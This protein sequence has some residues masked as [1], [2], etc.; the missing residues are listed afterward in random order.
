[1][2][3][4]DDRDV[5][6]IGNHLEGKNIALLITGGIAAYKSPS[7]IRHF[8]QYGANVKVYLSEEGKNFVTKDALSWATGQENYKEPVIERLSPNAEHLDHFDAYVIAPA[9]YNTIGKFAYGIADNAVTSVLASALGK[10]EDQEKYGKTNIIMMPTMHGSMQNSIYKENLEKLIQKGVRVVEP[11]YKWGKANLPD[12]H[13]IVV[14]TIRSISESYLKGKK[15]LITAGPTPASI[16]NVRAITNRFRGRTGIAIAEELYLRG[17][18]V[19]LILGAT[20]LSSPK[21]IPTTK[22]HGFQEYYDNVMKQLSE[23]E[24]DIGIF[25]AAVADYI[26]VE[27]V[28]GKIPSSGGLDQ[29]KLKQTPKVIKEVREK[30]PGLYMATF[31][32]ESGISEENLIKIAQERI[33]QGYDLVVADR[34]EEENFFHIVDKTG[35]KE[36]THSKKELAASLSDML[37]SQYAV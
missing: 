2:M 11:D 28:E 26:P 1:M 4:M 37:E 16:D 36:T 19:H 23:K 3:T 35:V 25:S 17:A 13:T 14:E 6:R 10:L 24:Y 15:I 33:K 20:G 34:T 31:K 21:Y 29:I 22:I 27:K 5:E 32:L 30:Y 8:R 9:T 18:D 7:L 12:T